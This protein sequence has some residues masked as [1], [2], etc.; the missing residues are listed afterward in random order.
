MSDF[1]FTSYLLL[2]SEGFHMCP[3]KS[4]IFIHFECPFISVL[5]SLISIETPKEK[6]CEKLEF[7]SK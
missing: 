4:R 3:I 7:W 6:V 5:A 1:I 2:N